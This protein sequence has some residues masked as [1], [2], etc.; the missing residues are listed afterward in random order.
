M[1]ALRFY[2]SIDLFGPACDGAADRVRAAVEAIPGAGWVSV[3]RCEWVD[4][5]GPADVDPARWLRVWAQ[6]NRRR[7]SG[8]AWDALRDHLR[9][10]VMAALSGRTP[11]RRPFRVV[12]P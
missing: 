10:K 8:P 9:E 4:D 12:Q 11:R 7:A 5:A 1:E 3:E 2:A 6:G